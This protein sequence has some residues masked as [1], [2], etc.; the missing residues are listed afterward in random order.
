MK[1]VKEVKGVKGVKEVKGVK[2]D[3]LA[4]CFLSEGPL[5][6]KVSSLIQVS[7]VIYISRIREF[8]KEMI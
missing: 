4:C 8:F 2:D 6:A 7:N 5:L 1:G 3:T